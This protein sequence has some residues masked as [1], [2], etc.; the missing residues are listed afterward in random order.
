MAER[1]VRGG[2]GYNLFI[3]KYFYMK[4]VVAF[5]PCP[6]TKNQKYQSPSKHIFKESPWL[7]PAILHSQSK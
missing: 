5:H 3:W 4:K 6:L 7:T 2:V 1:W